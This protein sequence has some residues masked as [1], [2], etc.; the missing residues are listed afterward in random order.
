MALIGLKQ[1][2]ELTGK[3][4]STIRRAVRSG[5]LSFRVGDSGQPLIDPAEPEHWASDN[6]SRLDGDRAGVDGRAA[7]L[8][9]ACG[10]PD[11][12]RPEGARY[13]WQ[14][15][16]AAALAPI[17]HRSDRSDSARLAAPSL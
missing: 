9:A 12:H 3:N 7:T 11:V 16:S 1:A 13:H 17:R 8:R 5:K 14:A 10:A 4:Q 2:A 15:E 6:P